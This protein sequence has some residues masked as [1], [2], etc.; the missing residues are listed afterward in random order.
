MVAGVHFHGVHGSQWRWS[1]VVPQGRGRCGQDL[2]H[3]AALGDFTSPGRPHRPHNA[4]TPTTPVV[5]WQ[6]LRARLALFACVKSAWEFPNTP[7]VCELLV[8]LNAK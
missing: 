6:M 7:M 1:E 8:D 2:V 4:I 5:L 3:D